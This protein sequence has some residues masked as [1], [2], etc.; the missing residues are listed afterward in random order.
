MFL[1]NAQ[2]TLRDEFAVT[3]QRFEEIP[4]RIN[5]RTA[6]ATPRLTLFMRL[7]CPPLRTAS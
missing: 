3:E 7:D 2:I 1:N 4:Y 5:E 6:G